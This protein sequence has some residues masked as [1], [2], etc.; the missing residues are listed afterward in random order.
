MGYNPRLLQPAVTKMHYPIN[1]IFQ[2]IQG[3][4]VFTGLPAIFVRLQGCPVGCPW[5]DTRHTWVVDP[6]REVGVQAVLDCSNESDGWSKMSTEQILA[7]F[8][9]LG[10]QARHVVITGGEPCLYDLQDLSAALI[11]AGYQVQI[12]TSGTSE[13]QTHEQTWVTVSPKINMKGG[14]PVLVSALER[15]NEIKH[16]VATERHV[17]ELDALLATASLR[18]NVVIALQPISQKPRATQLAMATCIARNWRLSIQTH[19]YLDID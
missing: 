6:A 4:G 9:Q 15:A 10:Y 3:E 2:T 17:E 14:L 16:P 1:E 5:C 8:Q 12:E 13:I 18:E 11:E 7:S 19:K